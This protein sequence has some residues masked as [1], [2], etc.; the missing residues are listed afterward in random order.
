[1]KPKI[2]QRCSLK[3]RVTLFSLVIFLFG[4]WSLAFF[5]TRILHQDMQRML[6]E[7]QFSAVSFMADN[8]NR[9]LVDRLGALN[10]LAG[11]IT[12]GLLSDQAALQA[13]LGERPALL[14]LFNSGVI[15]YR[16]DGSAIAEY[17]VSAGRTG[18]DFLDLE[19]LDATLKQGKSVISRPLIGANSQAPVF[20]MTVAIHDAQGSVIGALAGVTQLDKANFLEQITDNHYGKDGYYLLEEPKSRTIIIG[21]DKKRIMQALPPPGIN[22]LID[23]H[24]EGYDE[25]G[26]TINPLG[27]EVLASAKRIPA[28]NWF[29]VAALPTEEAFAPIHAMQQR[30][31]LLTILLTL[32]AGGLTWW[33]LRRQLSPMLTAAKTLAAL[34]ESNQ[35][36]QPLRITRHDEIGQLIGGF[37]DLLN[38][39]RIREEALSE[40]ETRFRTFF[41]KNSSVMLLINPS[42]GEICDANRTAEAFYGYPP[43]QLTGMFTCDINTMAPELIAEERQKALHD[44]RNYFLFR[45][46]LASGELRDVEVHS[47]PINSGGQAL[48]FSIIHDITARQEVQTA[49]QTSEAWFRSIFENANTGIATCDPSGRLTN[50]NEAFRAILGYPAETLKG[51]SLNDFSHPEDLS[52]EFG[53][54]EETLAGQRNHYHMTKR[55]IAGDGRTLWIDLFVTVVR[56]AEGEAN[57]F[58]GLV[59]DITERRLTEE[60]L[61]IAAAAF[62]SKEGQFVTDASGTILKVNKAFA[63]STGYLAEE[64]V[65]QTP[66]LLQSGRHSEDFYRT[67]W[68]SIHRTGGW[69]GEVWDRR[70]CGEVYPKWL[71]ITA[72][73]GSDGTVTNYIGTHYDI[74][75]RKKAEEKIETLAF[76]DQ[77]TGLPNRTLLLDRLKQSMKTSERSNRYCALLFIDLDNFK[78]LNDTQGHDAGDALLKQVAQRLR[79]CV[80][81]VDT[82]ARLGGDE[83][84]VVLASLS[85]NKEEAAHRTE[86]VAEHI[87]APLNQMFQIANLTYHNTASI[88]ATLFKGTSIPIDILMKQ[89]DLTMYKSKAAGRN[90]LRFFDPAME[91]AVKERASLEGDLRHAL[92]DKQFLLHY[93][94][95]VTGQYRVTGAE[96]LL[97]WRHPRRGM[98]SPADFIPLAE[99][100]GLILPLGRWVLETA[101]AQLAAW[102]THDELAHLTIS[103]NVSARQFHQ[104]EFVNQVLDVLK[105]TGANPQRLKLELTES[106]L[107]NDVEE[108]IE[109]MFALKAKGIGFSLDDFGTGYSSLSY[110][111]RLPLD[112]LKIDQSFVRD[113]LIDPNDAAI[114]KTIVA[115]AQSLGLGVIAE[116]VETAAQRD[117]LASAGCHAY[118]GYFFSRPLPVDDFE[119]F[120]LP[121]GEPEAAMTI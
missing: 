61:R 32:L 46:R 81:D 118:Q 108:I 28:A 105:S 48:L 50:F 21:T 67:M 109:K 35:P 78:N 69:Q 49:L 56:D 51:M 9:E 106:L 88:G 27:V 58:I 18:V 25:T 11:T 34:S 4:M 23:R 22:A 87:L 74:T 98:V 33:M 7:Q 47:T 97:R 72:V 14:W 31:L 90:T 80:R 15:A 12:P 96:V 73:M 91:V 6:G 42:S 84:V 99:E 112:Q 92:V 104:T 17:P 111:K 10:T 103:V 39:L 117:F 37:N 59:N 53:Y 44:E 38:T 79:T 71:T 5:A 52:A 115:L 82:V 36:L 20:A 121:M 3:T 63:E 113:V 55:Y 45:H 93:Q 57:Y 70:K 107:I 30:M 60:Q 120:A 66:Q 2:S 29:I 64:L 100:T 68:E 40:S 24:V 76:Y 89:A 19:T 8:I 85:T 26:V 114:A 41:E 110:L 43:G 54:I 102:A 75:E 94:A 16:Q 116:G 62:E 86:V 1:M 13:F 119:R 95:Q 83:F 101:C 65:G 77:L